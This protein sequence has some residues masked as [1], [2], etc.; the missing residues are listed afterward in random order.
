MWTTFSHLYTDYYVYQY[1]TGISG[2]HALANG[3][4]AGKKNAVNAYLEFLK[5]GSSDYPLDI[6][7][8]AG[9]DLTTP[10]AI[11]ETFEVLA[12]LV[13]KLEDLVG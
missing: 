6:L 9:V 8:R 2:A 3:I 12:G 11:E 1:G 4:L 10:R 7:K 13:D 5:A